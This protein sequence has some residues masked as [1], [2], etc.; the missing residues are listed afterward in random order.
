MSLLDVHRRS[1][2]TSTALSVYYLRNAVTPLQMIRVLNA[3][4]IRFVLVGCH[5]IG[6]WMD[7]P[8]ASE[9]VDVLVS[10]RGVS[11]AV[12]ELLVAFPHLEKNQDEAFVHLRDR[13]TQAAAIDIVKPTSELLRTALKKICEV[14]L[15]GEK[16]R[17]PSVEMALTLTFSRMKSLT[18]GNAKKYMDAHDFIAMVKVN[19]MI[20]LTLLATL[21]DLVCP[22]GGVEIVQTVGQAS[23]DETLTL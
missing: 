23:R 14:E 5:S 16:Y 1:L 4:G 7:E 8:R 6:G 9:D 13:K 20:D 11:K 19:P 21:G 3:A 22:D 17:I 12:R 10:A 18:W 15:A 2:V